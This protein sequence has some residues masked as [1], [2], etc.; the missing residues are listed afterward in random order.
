MP[1]CSLCNNLGVTLTNKTSVVSVHRRRTFF[2]STSM[3]NIVHV[4]PSA[5]AR[6][7]ALQLTVVL[8]LAGVCA[9]M[10][11]GEHARRDSWVVWHRKG[12]QRVRT[13]RTWWDLAFVLV[14]LRKVLCL[15]HIL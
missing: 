12:P 13:Y 7:P 15:H 9:R 11:K 4:Y 6:E 10:M 2:L 1:S 5:C 8:V 14:R 3:T